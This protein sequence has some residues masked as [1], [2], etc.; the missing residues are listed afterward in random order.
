MKPG[1]VVL[2]EVGCLL[3]VFA[4]VACAA[5]RSAEK[6]VAADLPAVEAAYAKGLKGAETFCADARKAETSGLLTGRAAKDADAFCAD[7]A[8]TGATGVSVTVVT[9]AGSASVSVPAVNVGGA[10]AIG[11]APAR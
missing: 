2:A 6:T 9:P 10:P 5:L 11:G 7:V 1:R 4:A 3:A 8:K